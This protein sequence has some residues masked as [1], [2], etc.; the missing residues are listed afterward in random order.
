MSE[1]I[2]FMNTDTWRGSGSGK[3]VLT[4]PQIVLMHVNRCIINGSDEWKGGYWEERI[5]SAGGV[6]TKERR[7]IPDTKNVFNN[8]VRMLR[9]LLLNYYDKK[10]GEDDKRITGLLNE[11]KKKI[12]TISNKEDLNMLQIEK[13][14]VSTDLLEC[15][16]GLAKRLNFFQ[17][18]VVEDYV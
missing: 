5:S 13:V 15:L 8:S 6:G 18:E 3:F 2:T 16:I 17:E 9:A 7:Y 10:M 11:I 1:D 4:F 14:E 12:K